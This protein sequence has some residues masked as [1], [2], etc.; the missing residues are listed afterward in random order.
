M[1]SNELI[2]IKSLLR[3]IILKN[4][5][6][7]IVDNNSVSRLEF[8]NNEVYI[9][10]QLKAS[11]L[12]EADQTKKLIHD[13]LLSMNRV[14]KVNLILTAHNTNKEN[15]N[16]S[17]LLYKPAKYVIVI[18]SG[19]GGVGK[20]TTA[21][22]LALSLL[23]LKN[24]VGILDADIFGPSLPKLTGTNSKPISNGKKI[25]PH[26]AL[27][28]QAMS[29][30]Y[31]VPEDTA[32]IWRGPMVMSAIEQLLR[33]VDWQELDFL[34]ID[35]PPGTG[36]AHLTLSQKAQL[37]GAIIVS[38]PQDLSL[39]DA[40]K[41]IN[42]FKK[43]NVPILGIIENMSYFHCLNCDTK[44]DIFG[45]GGAQKESEKLGIPFLNDIPLD[46]NIRITSD[47]GNP[48]LHKSPNSLI[49]Q[50]YLE[51]GSKII[52]SVKKL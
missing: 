19:K 45:N 37:T 17:N 51:I 49:A 50:K 48:I 2:E 38:T 52:S 21:I 10:L 11:Q 18:A 30:G 25:I 1:N 26:N 40:R 7:N 36:D 42:M 15:K 33:D 13:K 12:N 14:K 41:G 9:T 32:T 16:S 39:I 23:K 4:E 34:I 3:S 22:N 27:G 43:V 29:I 44:H 20:S 46:I 8:K 24:K 31:L 28:L 47:D 35:M 5:N 6:N